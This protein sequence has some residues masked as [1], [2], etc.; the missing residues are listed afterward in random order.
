MSDNGSPAAPLLPDI[1]SSLLAPHWAAA[2]RHRLAIPFCAAA[3][4]GA[5]QWPPRTNCLRC[6]GFDVEWREIPPHGQ[7]LTYFVA[8]KPLHPS[9]TDEVPYAAG[10]VIVPAGVKMLGRLVGLEPADIAIGM[11]L[12]AR[13]TERAPGVTLVFW[14]PD[15]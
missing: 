5:P 9:L 6:H 13:F 1:T 14:E 10:V 8:R 4:C 2:A 11:P 12:R 3:A 15:Q 7:L